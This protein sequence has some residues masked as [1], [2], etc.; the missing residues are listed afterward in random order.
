[1]PRARRAARPPLPPP[2]STPVPAPILQVCQLLNR[3]GRELLSAE[4]RPQR[5][6]DEAE[7]ILS[8][9][10]AIVIAHLVGAHNVG[11]AAF[12][13]YMVM[14]AQLAET[15]S[16]GTLRVLGT[17]A[18]ALLA[19]WLT[20]WLG[21]SLLLA[22]VALALVGGT[23]LYA[24][25]TRRRSYAWL[26]TSLTFSMVVLD[27]LQAPLADVRAFA[28]TRVLEVASGTVA[29][30]TVSLLSAWTVRP[31]VHG[32]QFFFVPTVPAASPPG[33]ERSAALHALQAAIGL[34]LLPPL[35]RWIGAETLSQAAITITAVMMVP[36]A[37]LDR[38]RVLI[39]TRVLHRFAGCLLG[40]GVAALFLLFSR[41]NLPATLL[42]MALGIAA[43][44]HLENSGQP[45]AYIGTQ[46]ALAFLVVFV[47]DHYQAVS[48]AP[49]WERLA[50][51]VC[52][53]VLLLLVREGW[54]RCATAQRARQSGDARPR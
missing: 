7:T 50:G 42:L 22:S 49:G 2:V 36:L 46:F 3:L 32:R 33:W 16:R 23:T 44:R 48:S 6:L 17:V 5:L 4:R 14:R 34:A 26:F 18:G 41:G 40:A 37:A 38:S 12:S 51:I 9:L 13:G 35:S 31:K 1:M 30:M 21:G 52:G 27:V 43:G 10:L 54:Y 15:L 8:V 39:T 45:F 20:A 25:L 24:A 47:P 29:C 19:W 28:Q 11:W 53:L